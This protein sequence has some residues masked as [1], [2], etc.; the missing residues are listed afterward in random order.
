MVFGPVE[1]GAAEPVTPRE[2][3]RIRHPQPTLL[4]RVDQKDAVQR[5]VRLPAQRLLGFLIEHDHAASG[6][7][8]LTRGGQTGQPSADHDNVGLQRIVHRRRITH[9]PP[10]SA[11]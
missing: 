2:V 1:L 10:P 6:L 4:T 3:E 11:M 8:S 7:G 5:P 9:C